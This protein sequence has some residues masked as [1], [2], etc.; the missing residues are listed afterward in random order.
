MPIR[1]TL[2][3]AMWFC[4]GLALGS[5]L[6]NRMGLYNWFVNIGIILMWINMYLNDKNRHATNKGHF[7]R[8]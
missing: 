4:F 1:K 2:I 6:G 7:R 8:D 3:C 5:A